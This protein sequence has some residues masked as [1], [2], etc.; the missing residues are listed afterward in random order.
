MSWLGW[1]GCG[2]WLIGF[3]IEVVADAQKSSFKSDPSNQGHFI[4]TGLWAWSRHPNYFGEIVLWIGMF[5][6]CSVDF[7]NSQWVAILSPLFV[8]FLLTKVSGIPMLEKRS[9]EKFG[10]D[11]AYIAYRD[12]TSVL[13]P[14]PKS[15]KSETQAPLLG[16]NNLTKQ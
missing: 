13:I 15:S 7:K 1:T 3:A 9:D 16:S 10:D 11:P 4:R 5:V 2:V 8:V 14:L 6:T 12:S